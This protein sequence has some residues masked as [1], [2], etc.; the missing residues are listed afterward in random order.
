[1]SADQFSRREARHWALTSPHQQSQ[2]D[3]LIPTKDR[4]NALAVTLAGLAAQNDP[5]FRV[6]ISD[7]ST[8]PVQ[9]DNVVSTLVRLLTV[10]GRRVDVLRHVPARGMAEQR[11]FLLQA[12]TS[13]HVLFLDDDV[14]LEPDMLQRLDRALDE[15]GC[16]LVGAAVQ[17]LSYID[18]RRP[19]ELTQFQPWQGGVKPERVRR[20][21]AE[22]DRFKLHNAANLT[23]IAADL[24]LERDEWLPYKIAWVGA[25]VMFRRQALVDVGGFDFWRELPATHVG[26]DVVAQWRVIERYGGAGI[27]PSGAVHLEAS[28]TLPDRRVEA[29]DVVGL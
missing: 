29:S 19:N 14:W 16:G 21:S 20:G 28:T 7:Q 24:G 8:E 6:I 27:V 22:F 18:D 9:D 17:G 13:R 1:M 26:E 2:V 5:P 23:H 15:L 10:Q 4:P 25:C 3:V 12:S 11:A